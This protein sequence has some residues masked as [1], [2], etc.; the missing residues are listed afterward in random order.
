[1][2]DSPLV[3]T[4][5]LAPTETAP[6][7]AQPQYSPEF[8]KA[9]AQ[10]PQ[11]VTSQV[12]QTLR[13]NYWQA[14]NGDKLTGLNPKSALMVYD[15]ALLANPQIAV[16]MVAQHE[17]DPAKMYEA[18]NKFVDSMVAKDPAKYGGM[19]ESWKAHNAA[20]GQTLGIV[21]AGQ[22]QPAAAPPANLKALIDQA[23]AQAGIDPRKMYGIVAGESG[24][25]P[26]YDK[27]ISSKE[28]SYGPFQLNRKGGLGNVFEQSTGLDLRDPNTI[29]AQAQWVANYLAKN[30]NMNIGGTW[31]GYR[32]DTDWNP[33]W[34]NAGYLSS[35]Q[36][37]YE[38]SKWQYGAKAAEGKA[39][40]APEPEKSTFE[41]A[42][43]AVTSGIAGAAE[44][45]TPEA[46]PPIPTT[47]PNIELPAGGIAPNQ[48]EMYAKALERISQRTAS[49]P[50][51]QPSKPAEPQ[52]QPAPSK[53]AET[54][55]DRQA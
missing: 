20:I 51:T 41:Q 22:A 55:D 47:K 10:L 24:H 14:V 23:A 15:T 48:R 46:A 35:S 26:G 40:P 34:G 3:V 27:N 6:T 1:M 43:D 45:K 33:K 54:T 52:A 49:T 53:E 32:G 5:G 31:F 42:A 28:E 12:P 21:P 29:G 16:E 50:P 19:A 17:N 44:A 11:Q 7:G 39:A 2:V 13:Y 37:A 9:D 30:P 8:L 25:G 18:R 38:P 4:A 36:T